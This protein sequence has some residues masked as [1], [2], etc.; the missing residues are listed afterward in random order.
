MSEQEDKPD[1]GC[2]AKLI[3]DIMED[4]SI[5]LNL[6]MPPDVDD[7]VLL[8]IA[9]ALKALNSGELKSRIMIDLTEKANKNEKL[10]MIINFWLNEEC[11]S[12]LTPVVSPKDTM[13]ILLHGAK[14]E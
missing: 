7:N 14:K 4:G 12:M 10:E 11:S 13:K 1:V 8:N 5:G 3:F 2:E 6:A 9:T